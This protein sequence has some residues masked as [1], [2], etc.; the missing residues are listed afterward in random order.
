MVPN[1]D[2]STVYVGLMYTLQKLL[3]EALGATH[4]D[5][6]FLERKKTGRVALVIMTVIG[7]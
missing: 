1:V 4:K 2:V 3:P 7:A 5:L 6:V